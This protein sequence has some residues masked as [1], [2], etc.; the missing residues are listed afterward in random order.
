ML[1]LDYELVS[2]RQIRV[3]GAWNETSIS[4]LYQERMIA[5]YR[6]QLQD[7]NHLDGVESLNPIEINES[8]IS[9]QEFEAEQFN[10]TISD[11][12]VSMTTIE[13]KP[14]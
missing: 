1:N 5:V 6:I 7:F 14:S 12:T 4:M 9:I 3:V 11:F 8:Q 13:P 10:Q 2:N